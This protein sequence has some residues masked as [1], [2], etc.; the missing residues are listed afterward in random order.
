MNEVDRRAVEGLEKLGYQQAMKRSRNLWH[1]LFMS[2][3]I[4]A[5]PLATSTT[6]ATGLIGGGP[7]T[8]FWGFVIVSCITLPVVLSLAEIC[9]K[10]PTSAG[11]YYWCYRFASPKTRRLLSWIT[12]WLTLVGNWTAA[13]STTFGSTQLLVS[14]IQIYRPKWVTESWET[15]LIFIG[16]A[17]LYASVGIFFNKAL[18]TIGVFAI[19]WMILGVIVI[20]VCLSVRA[21][22][23]RHSIGFA[24]GHF[25]PSAS[26]WTPGWSFFIGLLP[27][28]F[29]FS[30]VCMISSMAEE[31]H[32]PTT[33]L[34]RAMVWQVPIGLLTGVV[35]LLPILLT[36]PDITPLLAAPT[37]QPIGVLF[38]LVMGSKG[39][40]F[41]L[42]FIIFMTSVF[43]A[44]SV[45][46]A[47][48]RATW[49]FARDKAVPFHRFFAKISTGS[50][51]PLNAYLLSTLVQLL[52]GL[53]SLGPRTA[54]NAFVGVAVMCLGASNAMAIGV[55]LADRRRGVVDSPFSLGK[56]GPPLNIIAVLW[57]AFEIVLFSMPAV[58]PVTPFSM[59]YA[60]VVFV[61]FG[62]ISAVW[63]MVGGR[64]HYRG[65]PEPREFVE[66]SKREKLGSSIEAFPATC[67]ELPV[68]EEDKSSERP[69]ALPEQSD[70]SASKGIKGPA[71]YNKRCG[72]INEN[73]LPC[74]HIID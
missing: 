33:D 63:Y 40:G 4:M 19:W 39:G 46:C 8:V 59:N 47:S 57:I 66:G 35:F 55:S 62:V 22:A 34:P 27:P 23:G 26:G 6:I 29:T 56:L 58:V 18:P 24:L 49:A 71:N 50:S 52:L 32:N 68:D 31:V 17:M 5:V 54:Y 1:I 30:A 38:T 69:E 12:G 51:I 70:P 10:Y 13:L 61:G 16:L 15:Y 20:L 2:L 60:S 11:A 25:D 9:A 3:A 14:E 67:A 48:S 41:A 65:P 42:W 7:A 73:Y 74:T 44:I 53:V 43:C 72:V 28:A 36:L 37:G 45:C 21:A 64:H